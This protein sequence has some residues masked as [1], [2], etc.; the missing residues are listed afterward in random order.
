MKLSTDLLLECWSKISIQFNKIDQ[1]F[2]DLK[3]TNIF[4]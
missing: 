1:N 3:L 2:S 4:F